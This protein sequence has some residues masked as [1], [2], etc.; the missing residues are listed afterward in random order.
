MKESRPEAAD[1][2]KLN[3][4]FL[5]A[6]F[7]TLFATLLFGSLALL[8]MLIRLPLP[9][10]EKFSRFW[11]RCI[12]GA[13]GIRV[14]LRGLEHLSES[15][16]VMVG[17]HQGM[18]DILVLL[19]YLSR[20]PVFVA[21]QELFK[22]PLFGQAMLALGH[23]PVDRKDREKAIASIQ[24]GTQKLNKNEQ[25]VVFFPEGTR[26]RDGQMLPFKKGAFVFAQESGLPLTPFMIRGS[27]QALPPGV[28]VVRPGLIEV[29]FLPSV[30]PGSYSVEQ[31][32][33]LIEAVRQ[34]IENQLHLSEQRAEIPG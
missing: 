34:Q 27:Y 18:F 28:R 12:L 15:A 20:P 10:L 29:V 6:A 1:F 32:E 16:A 33:L 3:F 19:G 21:K 24:K 14:Q 4:R 13:S 7:V 9:V 11:A 26:T 25:K 31:R 22:I 23:I 5:F 30:D 17:N 2:P 8:G